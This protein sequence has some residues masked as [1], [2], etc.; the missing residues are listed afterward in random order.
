MRDIMD[1]LKD[2]T[3]LFVP[4]PFADGW[5]LADDAPDSEWSA[6]EYIYSNIIN[7]HEYFSPTKNPDVIL[8]GESD[9]RI[10][11]TLDSAVWYKRLPEYNEKSGKPL[12]TIENLDEFCQR[13]G[14]TVRYNV[15]K[16]EDEIIVPDVS[17]TVDN[18]SA[19]ALAWLYSA[20]VRIE[21]PTANLMQYVT[22][23][24]DKNLF[25][26]AAEW[27]TSK[28]WDGISRLGDLYNT[29]TTDPD[30]TALKNALMRRWLTSAVAASFMPNGVSAHGI[31]VFQ[32]AQ[33]L[34][35]TA[36][37]KSLVPD[38]LDIIKDGVQLNPANVDSVKQA[39]SNWIVELGELDSTFK[40]SDLSQLKAFVTRDKD[41]LRRPYAKAESQFARR[42]VFFGS[43]NPEQFL[44]DTTGNR[45]Y[46][47][48]AATG[49]DSQH[50]IDMQQLWREVYDTIFLAWNHDKTAIPWMLSPDEHE[51]L[52]ASNSNFESFDAVFESLL[53]MYDWGT[54]QVLW[55]WKS[56]TQVLNEMG[57]QNH[58][59]A[60]TMACGQHIIKFNGGQKKRAHGR[61]L[62]LVPEIKR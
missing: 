61:R 14:V 2:D 29:V 57:F 25:N 26:P 27:I 12:A 4:P 58:K 55:V 1:A 8:A 60:D 21:M 17:M 43:V 38:H 34:G 10:A 5:D 54:D 22:Y 16:K 23:I 49:I 28:P 47:T 3:V 19:A 44:H 18:R 6:D 9:N 30:K 31:L 46:W 32:G 33:Y 37:F 41:I 15:I 11:L 51:A 62:L 52:N 56:S 40:R 42:T 20:C 39:V 48:I 53:D 50:G 36:W 24:A 59:K 7:A 13:L 35:K 45:R